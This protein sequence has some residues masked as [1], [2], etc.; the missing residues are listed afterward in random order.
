MPDATFSKLFTRNLREARTSDHREIHN[1]LQRQSTLF[2]VMVNREENNF[3]VKGDPEKWTL[4]SKSSGT[5]RRRN[6][7]DPLVIQ[8]GAESVKAQCG[9]RIY[10]NPLPMVE[11]EHDMM[12]ADENKFADQL[13]LEF[14]DQTTDFI[15]TVD[16]DLLAVPDPDMENVDDKSAPIHSL[17]TLLCPDANGLPSGFTTMMGV[18]YQDVPTGK[19]QPVVETY[20]D[21]FDFDDGVV[22]ALC[23]AMDQIK[24]DRIALREARDPKFR[25]TNVSEVGIITGYNGKSLLRRYNARNNDQH[26]LELA[27]DGSTI[28][29]RPLIV[30]SELDNK[31]LDYR[32]SY[33]DPYPDDEP[34]FYLPNFKDIHLIAHEKHWMR[35]IDKDMGARQYDVDVDILESYLGVRARRRDTSAVV[36]PAA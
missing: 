6:P 10:V 32:T 16:D 25:E 5:T 26:G 18:D 27:K 19:W 8:R 36:V 1:L 20:G 3:K 28:R 24:F 4:F 30:V 15:N 9:L 23:K 22:E 11:Y 31:D 33:T 35:H 14:A 21:P 34:A 7:K 17:P 12:A 29:G 2:G 13:E